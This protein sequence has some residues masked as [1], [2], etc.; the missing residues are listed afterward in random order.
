[1]TIVCPRSELGQPYRPFREGLEQTV[2]ESTTTADDAGEVR[3]G[4]GEHNLSFRPF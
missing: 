2:A 4:A 1:M 3:V